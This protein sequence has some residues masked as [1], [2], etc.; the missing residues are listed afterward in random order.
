MNPIHQQGYV[1][2]LEA[3]GLEKTAIMETLRHGYKAVKGAL[4]SPIQKLRGK[5]AA[6][7][8]F[9]PQRVKATQH[10]DDLMKSLRDSGVTT[11]RARVKTPGSMAAKGITHTMPDDLLGMQTYAKGPEGVQ[12]TMDALRGAGVENLNAEA[13]TRKGYH[14]VNVKGQYQGTPME[15]Q[16]APSPMSLIGNQ[17]EH[18]LV[19]KQLTESPDANWFDKFIGTKVAPKMVNWDALGSMDPSWINEH[20][21]ELAAMGVKV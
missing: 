12:K 11:Q 4:G 16:I 20:L 18:S 14:G 8:M 5:P 9:R 2:A 15:M 17:L 10:G 3:A 19:Y 7:G 13:L 6:P 1:D 21:D